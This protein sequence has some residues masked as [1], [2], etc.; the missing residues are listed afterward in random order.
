MSLTL[1]WRGRESAEIVGRTRALCY[2]PG[3]REVEAYQ[4]R[5]AK[6]GRVTADDLLLAERDGVAVG[7]AT[8]YSMNM[9]VR[10]RAVGC[11]GVAYVGTIKTH[12]R[13]GGIA[14]Q[15]MLE[16]IRKGRERGQ[17]LSALMPF[18]ASFY[19]HFGYGVVERRA[20]WTIPLSVLPAGS[21]GGFEL[22]EGADEA[23]RACRQRMVEA[24]QCDVERTPGMWTH[25]TTQE[26]EGYVVGDRTADGSMRSW[27]VWS[28]QRE[29]EKDVLVIDDLAFESI[30]ALRRGL[31]F[32]GTLRDQYRAV[33]LTLPAN[34]Q[35]NRLLGE[36]Q[37]PHR[38]VTHDAAGVKTVTRMQVRVLDHLRLI[39]GLQLPEHV[40]G[41]A[42]VG[43]AESEGTVR[44]LRIEI[45]GGRAVALD[46]TA[47]PDVE[48]ADR[49]WAAI[50]MGDLPAARAA[51]MGLIEVNRP[52]AVALL[53]AFAAGPAPFCNEYF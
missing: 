34:V 5:L 50:A 33:R 46:A 1:T 29:N 3:V 14:S 21:S 25:W 48:C 42:V 51:E 24:G 28:E 19:E 23:R 32:F 52:A 7:T 6:D 18:R 10:G 36:T 39:G 20:T 2:A 31:C 40:R 13:S 8:S 47:A 17:V 9:W 43:I 35:L 16:T 38:S 26:N 27:F 45:D 22:I 4:Q 37:V 15:I 30:A 41:S 11:Q 12:R 44:T 49:D 53:D